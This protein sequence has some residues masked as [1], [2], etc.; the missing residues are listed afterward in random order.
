MATVLLNWTETNYGEDGYRIYR[1]TST[2]DPQN[3]PAPVADIAANSS[4]YEDSG[5]TVGVT[6]YYRVGVYIGA[7][8]DIS[9]EFTV[10]PE[11]VVF[12]D[13]F[14]SGLGNWV[15]NQYSEPTPTK[16]YIGTHPTTG[17]NCFVILNGDRDT[18]VTQEDKAV[19]TFVSPPAD[20]KPTRLYFECEVGA[21]DDDDV[22]L[23]SLR[24]NLDNDT[25]SVVMVR[26]SS[27]SPLRRLFIAGV[28]QAVSLST[29][30]NYK[31]L[32]NL[33]WTLGEW[34]VD[35]Q[36]VGVFTGTF[37]TSYFPV[38]NLR[39]INQAGESDA[40]ICYFDNISVI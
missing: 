12:K 36:G 33:D 29:G 38:D 26:D 20:Y 10:V 7:T 23:I 22:G 32:C 25:F 2:M 17:S 40:G 27:S 19:A 24:D 39:I 35:I 3:M 21:I 28:Q 30:I 8:E 31:I 13:D 18:G 5:L 15:I 4:S 14:E 37:N 1:S 34:E 6:Y 11:N 9:D 16:M